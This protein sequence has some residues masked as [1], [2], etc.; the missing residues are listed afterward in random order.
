MSITPL[1]ISGS[2]TASNKCYDG[3]TTAVIASR[4]LTG[5]LAGDVVSYGGGT[6]SFA[7]KNAA[8]GKTVTAT[9]LSLSGPDASNYTVNST[10][11]AS[12]RTRRCRPSTRVRP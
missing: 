1:V 12:R 5:V 9:G 6:G 7:D 8:N 3:T 11:T 2:I 10:A 4:S